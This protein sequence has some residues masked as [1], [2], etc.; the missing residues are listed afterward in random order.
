M[1]DIRNSFLFIAL[2]ILDTTAE[3]LHLMLLRACLQATASLLPALS[4]MSRRGYNGPLHSPVVTKEDAPPPLP[5]AFRRQA[6]TSDAIY[7]PDTE[8]ETS[9]TMTRTRW[10]FLGSVPGTDGGFSLLGYPSHLY[11][12]ADRDGHVDITG[13]G[14][15]SIYFHPPPPLD[16]KLSTNLYQVYPR[17]SWI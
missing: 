2:Y 7:L 6:I 10:V 17:Y 8:A 1:Y 11:P 14:R 15:C 5:Q 4:N 13:S 9:A 12:R 16:A 3:L